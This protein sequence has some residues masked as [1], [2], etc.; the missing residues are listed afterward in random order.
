LTDV[1]W[2]LDRVTKKAG[3]LFLMDEGRRRK[4][5]LGEIRTKVFRHTYITA[6]LQT[7]DHDEPVSLWTVAQELGH[8]RHGHD[9]ADLWPPRDH[10]P[11]GAGRRVPGASA[12]EGAAGA[13]RT[14]SVN[15]LRVIL[16]NA[17]R[18]SPRDMSPGNVNAFIN[19]LSYK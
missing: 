16:G 18:H 14:R 9:R 3:M 7:L 4:A 19:R 2:L 15:Q 17:A 6:R 5:E 13:A 1:R 8:S 11:S 12:S 10:S